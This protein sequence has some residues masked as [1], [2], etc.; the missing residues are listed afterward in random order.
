M[1]WH[2]LPAAH[3]KI[4][5]QPSPPGRGGTTFCCKAAVPAWLFQAKQ[6]YELQ[7]VTVGTPKGDRPQKLNESMQTAKSGS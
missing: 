3:S 5:A 1:S 4:W 7:L 2:T 6:A